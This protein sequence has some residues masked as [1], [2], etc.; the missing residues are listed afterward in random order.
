MHSRKGIGVTLLAQRW[1]KVV[2]FGSPMTA[3]TPEMLAQHGKET[4]ARH[5]TPEEAKAS[6]A[7]AAAEDYYRHVKH[8]Y[9]LNPFCTQGARNDWQRGFDN[10]GPRPYEDPRIVQFDTIYLR[11]RAAAE[12]LEDLK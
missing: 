9:D 10:A 6:A 2:D 1:D 8:G 3:W 7:K 4:M 12:I 5:N 11:G